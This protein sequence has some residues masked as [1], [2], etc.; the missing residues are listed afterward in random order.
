MIVEVI[1]IGTE[2]LLG[3]IVNTNAAEIGRRLAD[4]GLHHHH[5][6]V[7]GD[8]LDRCA[9]AIAAAVDR[10]EAVILTG[11]I[12]PTQDD[13]TREAISQATGLPLVFSDAYARHL[14]EWWAQRGQEMPES[15]LKQAEYPEG[16]HLIPNAKGTAP[17]LRIEAGDVWIFALPGVPKEMLPMLDDHV[18]PF[19]KKEA[20]G[21][22]ST[23][24][25]RVIRTWGESES[26]IAD[27]LGDLFEQAINPTLAFLASGGEIKIRLTANASDTDAAM[28]LIEPLEAEVCR[29]LGARVFGFDAEAIERVVLRMVGE[30]GW[31]LGTA[32]SATG[33]MIAAELTSV[34]GA[35]SVFRGGIIAY[36]QDA[37]ASRLGVGRD[38]MQ[39]HGVV[40]PE[41]A[42]AM[43][44]GAAERLG[45]DVAVAVTGSAG[46]DVQ[47][48]PA[49]T[50]ICAV[51]T[52]VDVRSKTLGLPGDRERVRTY[53]TTAALHFVRLAVSGEWWR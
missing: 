18:L 22:S 45:V 39:E 4:S 25:S 29:R 53:A 43:A 49:G 5:Q 10:A 19:L 3:Q 38:V 8:N 46:P 23:V 47:E 34:P 15:N 36:D 2:M 32:E 50:M 44:E 52:P 37:K 1:A 14:R 27:L 41:T 35:S 16:A 20:G 33:G 26:R 28:R 40:S 21:E 17:G 42:I 48:Q 30:N 6:V 24:H 7:V 9:E 31:T 11:G 12:G 51:R 13:L